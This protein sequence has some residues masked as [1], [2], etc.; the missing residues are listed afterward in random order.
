MEEE[1]PKCPK[2][3]GPGERV[4]GC[5]CMSC[6]PFQCLG[7]CEVHKGAGYYDYYWPDEDDDD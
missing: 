1:V 3:G 2:C 6:P 5:R 7:D 4:Y